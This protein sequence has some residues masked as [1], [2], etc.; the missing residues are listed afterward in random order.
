MVNGNFEVLIS[1]DDPINGFYLKNKKK[2]DG[3]ALVEGGE[4]E[5]ERKSKLED[6]RCPLLPLV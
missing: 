6:E 2:L 3:D 5:R 4:R 1:E